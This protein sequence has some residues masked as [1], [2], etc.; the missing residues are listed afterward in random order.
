MSAKMEQAEG[1][2]LSLAIARMQ[3]DIDQLMPAMAVEVVRQCAHTN[4]QTKVHP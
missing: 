1:L 2:V 3:Y 4:P